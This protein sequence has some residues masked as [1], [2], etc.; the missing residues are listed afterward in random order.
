MIKK[1][2]TLHLVTQDNSQY[3]L[4]IYEDVSTSQVYTEEQITN[5]TLHNPENLITTGFTTYLN[6]GN[7]S[8]T[9][10]LYNMLTAKALFSEFFKLDTFSLYKGKGSN[11][12]KLNKC[13]V[14][15]ITFNTTK[16]AL[17]TASVS[18]SFSNQE[19]A[20]SVP[21]TPVNL[22]SPV[23]TFVSGI[24]IYLNSVEQEYVNSFTIELS[25]TIEWL[26]RKYMHDT[27][28][29]YSDVFVVK[30]RNIFG[31][32]NLHEELDL[33]SYGIDD[34]LVIIKSA[35]DEF[36]QFEF[37]KVIYSTRYQLDEILKKGVDFKVND[38]I[39]NEVRFKGENIL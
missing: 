31:N 1:E 16:D 14:E 17:I 18:G 11:L 24:G 20:T 12:V 27:G 30:E 32:F 25:N 36:L 8:F 10:P 39:D 15:S 22:D 21:G 23:Y 33:P 28:P 34:L 26:P 7:F 13:V 37:P 6:P 3:K 35:D 19:T 29:S 2:I 4:P 9:L 5:K 38:N